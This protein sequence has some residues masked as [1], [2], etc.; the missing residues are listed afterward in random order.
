MDR[1]AYA[2]VVREERKTPMS[3]TLRLVSDRGGTPKPADL[4][5]RAAHPAGSGSADTDT[6]TDTER[7]VFVEPSRRLRDDER[8]A[9]TA[10]DAIVIMAAV[11]FAG[12]LVAIMRSS[13]IRS[14]LVQLV[15]NALGAAG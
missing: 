7:I 8:G 4:A 2:G 10:E 1:P 9:V 3:T 15:E 6:D 11:A 5:A 12:L 13:E 14:M